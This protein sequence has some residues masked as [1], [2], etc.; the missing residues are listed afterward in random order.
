M[1]AWKEKKLSTLLLSST[2]T[3]GTKGFSL[4]NEFDFYPT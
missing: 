2:F 4:K 3:K 1:E